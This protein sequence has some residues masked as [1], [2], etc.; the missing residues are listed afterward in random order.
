M[1]VIAGLT[2]KMYWGTA[3]LNK[4]AMAGMIKELW[5][6]GLATLSRCERRTLLCNRLESADSCQIPRIAGLAS[7]FAFRQELHRVC[8][9]PPRGSEPAECLC[10]LAM[11]MAYFK[12]WDF[13]KIGAFASGF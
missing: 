5:P 4:S 2:G 13:D 9:R 7:F 8:Q 1:Q 3:G 12:I 6:K 10:P 11:D